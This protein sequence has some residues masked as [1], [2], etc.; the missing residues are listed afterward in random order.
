MDKKHFKNM[1]RIVSSIYVSILMVVS[2]ILGVLV[3][4][5]KDTYTFAF[6]SHIFGIILFSPTL[7]YYYVKKSIDEF[8]QSLDKK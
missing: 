4:I 6:Y 7:Y 1:D 8:G 5:F 2:G 3:C